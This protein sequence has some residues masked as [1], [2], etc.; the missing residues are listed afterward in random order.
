MDYIYVYL[1]GPMAGCTDEEAGDWRNYVMK[2]MH[3][4]ITQETPT[5]AAIEIPKTPF[6][7]LNPMLRDYRHLTGDHSALAAVAPEIVELDKRDIDKADVVFVH[8]PKISVGTSMEVL[9]AWENKKV[10]VTVIPKDV[11]LSP[12]ITY[13]ST[14]IC[15]SL[16]EGID[17]VTKNIR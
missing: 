8:T 12:W 16:D 6:Y 10:V 14:K 17:W 4:T 11:S 9:Y 13:H 3:K 2:N 1:A 7:F 15:Y 5:G